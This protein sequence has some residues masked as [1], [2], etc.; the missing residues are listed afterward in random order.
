M[1]DYFGHRLSLMHLI[2][3]FIIQFHIVPSIIH[4]TYRIFMLGYLIFPIK[5]TVDPNHTNILIP[6]AIF[7]I[8]EPINLI[9]I[10]IYFIIKFLNLSIIN[11]IFQLN[12]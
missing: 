3:F 12:Y 11:Y 1:I 8:I 5:L 9:L 4:K 2:I 7:Q 10:P 6:L